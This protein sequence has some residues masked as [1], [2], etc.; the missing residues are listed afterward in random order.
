MRRRGRLGRCAYRQSR[1]LGKLLIAT[2]REFGFAG[3]IPARSTGGFMHVS[4]I[5]AVL[6][7][8]GYRCAWCASKLD[9]SGTVCHL[10]ASENDSSMVAS[11]MPCNA[12][13]VGHWTFSGAYTM[14]LARDI[15]SRHDMFV[16]IGAF[17][18]YLDRVHGV[19]LVRTGR[20]QGK[21]GTR[22][23]PLNT[24]LAR[25]E[26]QRNAPLDLRQGRHGARL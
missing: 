19:E 7:R 3:S 12:M 4:V 20:M 24:A 16:V 11:C 14:Q 26:V 21:T 18:D 10:D 23:T 6:R 2:I 17:E 1:S 25:I 8:A 22:Q 15:L 5:A 9:A 13:F